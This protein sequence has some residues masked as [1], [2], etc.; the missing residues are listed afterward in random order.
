M[1]VSLSEHIGSDAVEESH[2]TLAHSEDHDT[3]IFAVAVPV[4]CAMA[5][6]INGALQH[7]L[8][9]AD[10]RALTELAGPLPPSLH[11]LVE[12]ATHGA[13][14]STERRIG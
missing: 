6:D 11:A 14:R 1:R 13:A 5:E 7:N 2:R 4:H 10:A 8:A 3:V 9:H 12:R